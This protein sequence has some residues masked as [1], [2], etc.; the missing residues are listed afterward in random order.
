[1]GV[2]NLG[3]NALADELLRLISQQAAAGR[4]DKPQFAFR[5]DAEDS[6]PGRIQQQACTLLGLRELILFFLQ[7]GRAFIDPGLHIVASA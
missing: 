7:F 2:M 1:M 4:V 5:I 6:L 3:V